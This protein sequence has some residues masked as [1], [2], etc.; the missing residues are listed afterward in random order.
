MTTASRSKA[1]TAT[2]PRKPLPPISAHSPLAHFR[3]DAETIARFAELYLAPPGLVHAMRLQCATRVQRIAPKEAQDILRHLELETS[4]F[5]GDIKDLEDLGRPVVA[6]ME[7]GIYLIVLMVDQRIV[8]A[9]SGVD[10][11]PLTMKRTDFDR[12]WTQG[13]IARA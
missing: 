12:L 8:I 11:H 5:Q 4:F 13:W 1:P 7:H 10:K 3:A 9:Q 2:R 6:V